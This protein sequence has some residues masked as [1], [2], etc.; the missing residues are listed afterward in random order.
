VGEGLQK[1]S[2]FKPQHNFSPEVFGRRQVNIIRTQKREHSESWTR[3]I[4]SLSPALRDPIWNFL[5]VEAGL[6]G[7]IG[8]IRR[9]N[10]KFHGLHTQI[11]ANLKFYR[12]WQLN[13]I[14]TFEFGR[15]PVASPTLCAATRHLR[16]PLRYF[17]ALLGRKVS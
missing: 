4:R 9:M 7:Q 2:W 14:M 13:Q 17:G 3:R 8:E 11:I 12:F 16:L 5:R 10:M 1:L 15:F 6:V